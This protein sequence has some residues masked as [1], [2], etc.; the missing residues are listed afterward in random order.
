MFYCQQED[1]YV[2]LDVTCCPRRFFV[3]NAMQHD[4]LRFLWMECQAQHFMFNQLQADVGS[5]DPQKV[6]C[7]CHH[8]RC[9]YNKLLPFRESVSSSQQLCTAPPAIS[10]SSCCA[11][12]VVSHLRTYFGF[13]SS[14]LSVT[15]RSSSTSLLSFVLQLSVC[16]ACFSSSRANTYRSDCP[17]SPLFSLTTRNWGWWLGFHVSK[18]YYK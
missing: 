11:G 10:I 2:T 18:G 15:P 16:C 9:W 6:K 7:G 4:T 8:E 3:A 12:F 5:A 13:T 1:T 17:T 14:P